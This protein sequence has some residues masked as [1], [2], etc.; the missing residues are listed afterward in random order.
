MIRLREVSS[1]IEHEFR[2]RRV[3]IAG[4]T[5][6]ERAAVE[7]HLEELGELGVPVPRRVPLFFEVD[8]ALLTTASRIQVG[9]SFTSGEVEPVVLVHDGQ[10]LLTVGSDH[11]D[12]HVERR[13]IEE[14]KRACPKVIAGEVLPLAS[15]R[16]LDDLELASWSGGDASPYQQGRMDQLLSLEQIVGE[17]ESDGFELGEGDVLFLGTL[18]VLDGELHASTRFR[19]RLRDPVTGSAVEAEYEIGVDGSEGSP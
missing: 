12:R 19:M 1:G 7:A 5:G 6:R 9:G 15:I 4:F 10:R 2:P 16:D 17:L 14:S 13:S 3:V 11:T 18:P 8:P